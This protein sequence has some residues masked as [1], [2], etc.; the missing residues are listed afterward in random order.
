MTGFTAVIV[1][2]AGLSVLV[3]S[4][5]GMFP[6][7]AID[8]AP[9]F[10]RASAYN[11]IILEQ[12]NVGV[13]MLR[14]LVAPG[15][16][17][18]GVFVFRAN[19]AELSSDAYRW[20]PIG[21]VDAGGS[22]GTLLNSPPATD[23]DVCPN[24]WIYPNWLPQMRAWVQAQLKAD[25]CDPEQ[26]KSWGISAVWRIDT[27]QTTYYFKSVPELFA[28]EPE[29]TAYLADL[30]GDRV[31][32][33]AAVDHERHWMLMPE[34]I[35]PLLRDN[36]EPAVWSS[37]A[38]QYARMQIESISRIDGLLS[39]G[40][41]DRRIESLRV[42]VDALV[43]ALVD[44]EFRIDS[45]LSV[46]EAVD[47]IAQ[48][49]RVRSLC[50]RL[51]ASGIPDTLIH[52][53]LH[54]GNI[55]NGVEGFVYFDWTDAAVSHPFFDL[56]TLVGADWLRD[57]VDSRDAILEAYCGPWTDL[58]PMDTLMDAVD[59]ALK[60][61]PVYHAVSYRRIRDASPPASRWELGPS[62]GYYLRELLVDI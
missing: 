25:E 19:S 53:D 60:L 26:V 36:R 28:G 59:V 47:V 55:V 10:A 48:A 8:A 32:K 3:D 7:C 4:N 33:V 9:Y 42:D 40:C 46:D 39:V 45:G 11:A 57:E 16:N 29:I 34:F 1:D 12:L 15:A 52:G 5:T 43:A 6:V 21:T 41:A 61:A 51:A 17:A 50:E 18:P 49:D 44:D 30:F 54:A 24:P 13:S 56:L 35:G 22:I 62:I 38:G 31:P 14:C 37:A 23:L 27:G 58:M 2:P 20:A